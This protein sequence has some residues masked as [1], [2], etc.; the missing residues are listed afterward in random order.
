MTGAE[1]AAPMR[2]KDR[3][4]TDFA[5]ML[6][7]VDACDCC[8]LG[9]V[10]GGEAY[11][12]PMSFGWT[13]RD[14]ALTLYFHCAKDGRK[15]RL[16]QTQARVSFEM[17]TR[18]EF[19]RGDAACGCT[20]LYQSVM[21]RGHVFLIERPDEKIHALETILAHY[22]PERNW[23]LGENDVNAVAILRLEV[24]EW[25]CKAHR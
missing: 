18:H 3:E 14:G 17:D 23:T 25:S 4:I 22:A 10:D 11:I 2:R 9:L 16:L 12:V 15:L 1:K 24:D 7:A 19:T 21:G 6:A 5:Q 8:R 20:M 13:A